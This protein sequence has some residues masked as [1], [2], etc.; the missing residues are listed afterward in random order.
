MENRVKELLLH[1]RQ[2]KTLGQRRGHHPGG[3]N[4]KFKREVF[5]APLLD[6]EFALPRTKTV[7][8]GTGC[9]AN[10]GIDCFPVSRS[11]M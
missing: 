3:L 11:V 9:F 2:R 5:P 10:A 7:Y 6:Q 4:H 1:R 8:P